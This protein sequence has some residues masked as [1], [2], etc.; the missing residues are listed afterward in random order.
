MICSLKKYLFLAVI[1]FFCS[2]LSAQKKNDRK[3]FSGYQQ[4]DKKLITPHLRGRSSISVGGVLAINRPL[5]NERISVEPALHVGYNYLILEDR[6]LRFSK[7]NKVKEEIKMSFGTHLTIGVGGEALF[8][9]NYYKPFIAIRGR[10]LGW[11]FFSE[12][13]IGAH[14]FPN[15]YKFEKKWTPNFALETLRIRFF[16]TRFF[17]HHTVNLDLKNNYLSKDRANW[18]MLFALRCYI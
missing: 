12:Y 6:K 17:L 2:N 11:Y 1:C 4:Y 9:V 7:K 10:V 15:Y 3:G 16:K 14:R 18:G 8:T 13:G 5:P